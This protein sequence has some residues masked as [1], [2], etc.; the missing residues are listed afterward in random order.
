MSL[1]LSMSSMGLLSYL[2]YSNCTRFSLLPVLY[3]P[4]SNRVD[5][6][7]GSF[8]MDTQS[9]PPRLRSPDVPFSHHAIKHSVSLRPRVSRVPASFRTQ[10]QYSMCTYLSHFS[11][12]SLTLCD[13][14]DLRNLHNIRL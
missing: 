1:S 2:P 9:A 4:S 3:F 5:Q 7:H 14:A 6:P 10:V 11:I 13:K 12:P 8:T